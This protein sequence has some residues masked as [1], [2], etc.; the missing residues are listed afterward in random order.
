MDEAEKEDQFMEITNEQ[1]IDDFGDE[2]DSP[3]DDDH[4]W[5]VRSKKFLKFVLK[6]G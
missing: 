6:G 3:E 4:P 2:C 1:M 5:I